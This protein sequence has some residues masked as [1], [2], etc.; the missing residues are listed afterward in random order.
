MTKKPQRERERKKMALAKIKKRY[1]DPT[2]LGSLSSKKTFLKYNKDLNPEDVDHFFLS[3]NAT[4]Q[5]YPNKLSIKGEGSRMRANYVGE[6][7]MCDTGFFDVPQ[8]NRNKKIIVLGICDVYSRSFFARIL[9]NATGQEAI[10]ALKVVIKEQIR[11]YM[12]FK[13]RPIT[14]LTD[15]GS[16]FVNKNMTAWLKSEHSIHH[17][18][19]SSSVSKAAIIERK[20]RTLKAKVQL[21]VDAKKFGEKIDFP[22]LLDSICATLNNTATR[23]LGN[24]TP[25]QI[26]RS[27]FEAT[28]MLRK[29]MNEHLYWTG[30]ER[31]QF[32]ANVRRKLIAHIGQ[33]T[34]ITAAKA[35][36]FQK[37]HK[38]RSSRL[39]LFIVHRIKVPIPSFKTVYSMYQ[40]RDLNGEIISGFFKTSEIIPV[41]QRE[42]PFNPNY[43]FTVTDWKRDET[44]RGMYNVALAGEHAR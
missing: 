8:V 33:Y 16:E 4:K 34:R 9:S 35:S 19:L 1:F 10:K 2:K 29:K 12:F 39:E 27:D 13:D 31:A 41:P 21:Y 26:L 20:W 11:P 14:I 28:N 25:N 32:Y 38:R 18:T 42:S 15:L 23:V 3:E 37:E 36:Y 22:K 43:R 7:V 5:W 17:G 6:Y 24:A 30:Q 40:L 44:K